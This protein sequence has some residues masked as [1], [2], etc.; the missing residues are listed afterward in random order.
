MVDLTNKYFDKR[1][2]ETFIIPINYHDLVNS[3]DCIPKSIFDLNAARD[4][5]ELVQVVQDESL[6]DIVR[7]YF[8]KCGSRYPKVLKLLGS[9][10]EEQNYKVSLEITVE[11]LKDMDETLIVGCIALNKARDEFDRKAFDSQIKEFY[12]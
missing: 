1:T 7:R 10:L 4:R 11:A 12:R 2:G 9:R 8:D 3:F 5:Y 6:N